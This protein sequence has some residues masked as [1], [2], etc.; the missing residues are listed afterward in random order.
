MTEPTITEP[1]VSLTGK[2]V[3]ITGASG[4]QGRAHAALLHRL[5][6]RLVLTDLDHEGVLAVAAPYGADAIAVRHDVTSASDW[7]TVVDLARSTFG[8][9]D[10]LVNNAGYCPVS[11]LVDTDEATIRR[12]MDINLIGPMLGMRAVA[13]LM[14]QTGGSIINIS[15]TAGLAGYANRVPYAASK[16]GLLGATR[17]V[18]REFGPLNIRVNAI[19]PGA[20]DTPMISEETRQ[21]V[22]FISTIPIPRAGRPDEVSNMV[23]FLASDASSYCTGHEFVVDG[24]QV[25]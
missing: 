9:L 1:L 5:G 2:V 8:R 12:T 4:G 3:L 22:G 13:D 20:V 24:G 11:S 14:A 17:S 18:A 16:W 15:S 10:V 7:D 21:G 19:C 25:A 6:A 23:A